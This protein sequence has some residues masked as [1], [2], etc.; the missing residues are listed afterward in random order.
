MKENSLKV[1]NEIKDK[2]ACVFNWLLANYFKG[3]SKKSH[4]LLTSNEQVNLNLDDLIIKTSKSEKLLGINI[5]HFL[6]FNKD[7]SK[8]YKKVSQKL[9]ASA[10]I[11]SYLNKNKLR[12]IINAFFLFQFG[13]CPLV[14]MYHNRRY[15]NKINRLHER[16]LR[17]V[18]KDYI[19]SFAEI[20]SEGKSVTVHDENVQ[21]LALK[22][23]QVKNEL[24]P[25][26]TLDLLKEVI[27]PYNVRNGLIYGCY[28]VRIVCYG[29]E[30]ITYLGLKIWSSIPDDIRKSSPLET[31]RQKI[32]LWKSRFCS[33][34]CFLKV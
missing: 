23:Y 32:K 6:T 16:M 8:L 14:W 24:C 31:L 1:L 4:F 25:K 28:K 33:F 18:Y 26:I 30:T 10:S 19:S 2:V 5:D 15:N 12:L 22:I 7:V 3:N 9:H 17:I 13:Y 27:H 11:S 21:K 29:T 34:V 20:I